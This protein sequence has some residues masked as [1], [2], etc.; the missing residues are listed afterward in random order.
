MRLRDVLQHCGIKDDAVYI[1]YNSADSHLSGDPK[2][3]PI[4]RGVPMHKALEDE[5]LIAWALNGADIPP[6]HGYPLR[7]VCGGWPASA[8]GKWLNEIL[9]RDRI[10]DG[11]KMTGS[12]YRVPCAPVAPGTK[13]P[14]TQMCIIQSMPVKSLITFPKSGIQHK[15]TEPLNLRGHAWAG[16]RKVSAMAISI[17]FGAT[18]QPCNLQPPANRLAWQQW[19][20]KVSFPQ[21]G[22]FEIWARATDDQGH[23]QP[24]VVPGWNPKGYLNNASHRIAVAVV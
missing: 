8:S 1:G 20:T 21:S 9:I 18:W 7:L 14:D 5:T 23:D 12:A 2:L 6:L 16:D 17:D 19:S 24:I 11:A 13:V 22:Y 10:H 4:S 15:V 3:R